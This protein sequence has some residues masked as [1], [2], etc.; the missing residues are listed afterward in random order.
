MIHDPSG[1][2]RSLPW[3]AFAT[4]VGSVQ[5]EVD[6][7]RP[8]RYLDGL[9]ESEVVWDSDVGYGDGVEIDDVDT[10]DEQEEEVDDDVNEEDYNDWDEGEYRYKNDSDN[11]EGGGLYKPGTT[12]RGWKLVHLY[13]KNFE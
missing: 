7:K 9:L 5:D 1:V 2:A 11:S 8:V 10:G 3:D 13:L 12:N 4:E 6:G